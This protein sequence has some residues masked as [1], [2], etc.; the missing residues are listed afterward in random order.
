MER[1]EEIHRQI[2][3]ALMMRETGDGDREEVR[4]F[5]H[6]MQR[7]KPPRSDEKPLDPALY[8]LPNTD[9]NQL[10]EFQ[11]KRICSGIG[12][13][14]EGGVFR[15]VR[16][17][18]SIKK[19]EEHMTEEQKRRLARIKELEDEIIRTRASI[20]LTVLDD[21]SLVRDALNTFTGKPIFHTQTLHQ[22]LK[23]YLKRSGQR[24]DSNQTVQKYTLKLLENLR[25]KIAEE[26]EKLKGEPNL[27]D[28]I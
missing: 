15:L 16:F 8:G 5:I 12:T 22:L 18:D 20:H 28:L 11:Q 6:A 3:H 17:Y 10:E 2:D 23:N 7:G 4:R 26:H 24:T 19:A 13:V 1:I 21:S 27:A 25:K 14:K 9:L